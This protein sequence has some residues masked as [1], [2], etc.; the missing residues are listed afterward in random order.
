MTMEL[1]AALNLPVEATLGGR[2]LLFR[3]PS[4][5]N[6]F[7]HAERKVID[8]HIARVQQMGA[9]L[10]GGDRLEFLARGLRD[11]PR[12]DALRLLVQERLTTLGG[13]QEILHAALAVDQPDITPEEAGR[14]MLANEAEAM[15]LIPL[16]TGLIGGED[17][18]KD[19]KGKKGNPPVAQQHP[20]VSAGPTP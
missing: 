17:V 9:V 3:R 8:A 6:I 4:L 20:P 19:K 2:K 11:M 15:A 7:G 16:L 18:P 12:G 10:T 14:L 1:N 5:A 13:M